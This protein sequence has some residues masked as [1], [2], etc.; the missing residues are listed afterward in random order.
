MLMLVLSR[1]RR[2]KIHSGAAG[3][4]RAA[5]LRLDGQPGLAGA[6]V[7]VVADAVADGVVDVLLGASVWPHRLREACHAAVRWR[8]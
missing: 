2:K 8:M 1:F 3:L 6:L 5:S 4:Q 7:D